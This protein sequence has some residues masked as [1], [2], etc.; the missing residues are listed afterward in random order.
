MVK[1]RHF[2]RDKQLERWNR[3]AQKEKEVSRL[4]AE[5]KGVV[6]ITDAMESN[7]NYTRYRM[8]QVRWALGLPDMP[9]VEF[10]REVRE[11]MQEAGLWEG[12]Q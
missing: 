3:L 10:Q 1:N 5:G 4:L 9:L 12:E 8:R 2:T 6:E 7:R 11:F